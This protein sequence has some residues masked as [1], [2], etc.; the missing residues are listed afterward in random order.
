[1][2]IGAPKKEDRP[3]TFVAWPVLIA[4]RYVSSDSILSALSSP[5]E[6]PNFDLV[7]FKGKKNLQLL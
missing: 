2:A 5:S 3:A 1:L 6:H 4:S 7:D